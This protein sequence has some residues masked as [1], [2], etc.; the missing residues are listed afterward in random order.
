MDGDGDRS[1]R[2]T[3]V[4]VAAGDSRRMTASG[5]SERKPWLELAGRTILERSCAALDACASV[6]ELVVVAHPDDLERIEALSASCAALGKLGAV[7]AGGRERA[8]S[9]RLG[10]RAATGEPD[11]LA[12]HDAARPLVR[13][14]LVERAI[15]AAARDGAALL[16]VPVDDTIKTSE[17]GR[18]AESTL[19]RSSLWRAQTPQCFQTEPFLELLERAERDG[20]RP[21]DDAAL[22]ERYK[23][24]VTIVEGSSTNLKI[25]R[26]ED[27]ELARAI[28]S[29][30][31][32]PS[33]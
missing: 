25:T 4:L 3:A 11:V 23:G 13:A 28:L 19:E 1:L 15:Q 27:L 8:D 31:E 7:V 16:A 24:P 18:R 22:W 14:E 9:V 33:P 10:A 26:A 17:H 5:R 29:S 32:E 21:T 12:V 30:R 6:R 2:A 20:F